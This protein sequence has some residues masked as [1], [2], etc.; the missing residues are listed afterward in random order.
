MS[1]LDGFVIAVPAANRPRFIE[2]WRQLDPTSV[3]LREG[4]V[5]SGGVDATPDGDAVDS[6][7]AVQVTPERTVVFG[8]EPAVQSKLVRRRHP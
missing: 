3:G 4:H 2:R 8:F 7:R 5:T 6:R 1:Y